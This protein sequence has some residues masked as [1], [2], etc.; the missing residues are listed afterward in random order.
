[1]VFDAPRAA[2]LLA[3]AALPVRVRLISFSLDDPARWQ[4]PNV[5]PPDP[6]AMM[7]VSGTKWILDGTPIERLAYVRQAYL[8][9]NGW[10][11][12]PNFR[13][14]VFDPMLARALEAQEPIL[15]HAV[16]DAAI[17]QLF[18][19]MRRAGSPLRWQLRRPRI[20]HGDLLTKDLFAEAKRFGV[21]LVQNP[22]HFFLPELRDRWG[23]ERVARAQAVKSALEAG[24]PLA[25]GSD[26]PIN[27]FL[28]LRL[29]VEHP[30][31]PS[32]ALTLDQAVRAYTAGSA[33][34]EFAEKEKG[35]IA[36]G[37]LADLAILSQDIFAAP[38]DALDRTTSVVTIV[39]GRVVHDELTGAN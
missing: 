8:D 29:A 3:D 1:M 7:A 36:P 35:T 10:R 4:A 18:A 6:A 28:N 24:V 2:A 9:R 22:T 12:A 20:E 5:S 37:M 32:E 39:G 15:V 26:G 38:P 31:N 17:D 16:G 14:A 23:A 13:P 30:N 21:V 27:P 11:G 34:A 25:I 33:F 19:G